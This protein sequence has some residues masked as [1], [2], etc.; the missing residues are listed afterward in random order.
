MFF[1]NPSRR[2]F[3]QATAAVTASL[4][5]PRSL[6]ASRSDRSFWFL[7]ADSCTSW[8]VADPV[9]WSLD[10]AHEP[11]LERATEGLLKLTP[12]DGDRIIRL[13]VRRCGLNLLELHPQQVVVHHWGQHRA[14]LR[15][16]FQQ[17]GLARPDVEV[18]L[19]D[20]KQEAVT[21]QP[22]DDFLFGDRFAADFPLD[23]YLGKWVCRF[24]RQPDDFQP[25]P[26]TWSGLAWEGVED[27]RIPWA[28]LKSAWRRTT[29]TTCLNCD[30]PTLLVNF[31]NPWMGLF[32]R[33]PRFTWACG[34]CRRFFADNSVTDVAGWLATNLD[35]EVRPGYDMLWD[36]RVARGSKGSV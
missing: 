7:H 23:I 2:Q 5:L 8:P 9:R 22:G 6:V 33:S 4:V 3:I 11:V 18:V 20:R 25:A 29:P 36:R 17:H 27:N 12:D 35:P 1:L 16:F 10:H 26:E 34:I 32:N 24:E 13:V 30:Q 19:R 31:G 21:T 14:D 28:A 15:P